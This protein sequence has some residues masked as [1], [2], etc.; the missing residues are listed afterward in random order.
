M[1]F[2]SA[3]ALVSTL[4][5]HFSEG[6]TQPVRL[7]LSEAQLVKELELEDGKLRDFITSI[8]TSVY[9]GNGSPFTQALDHQAI[10]STATS[11][12]APGKKTD[13]VRA[14]FQRGTL[15][16]WESSPLVQDYLGK[17]FKFLRARTIEGH[18]GL[19]FRAADDDGGLNY[20][21]LKIGRYHDDDYRIR[22]IFI[23]GV[24]E[25][26]SDTLNRTFRH[27]ASEFAPRSNVVVENREVSAAFVMSLSRIAEMNRNFQSRNYEKVCQIYDQL[28]EAAK[29]D[30]K[31]MLLR[32]EAAE[33]LETDRYHAA[34]KDWAKVFP[35]EESLPL[36]FIEY[37]YSQGKYDAA[38]EVIRNLNDRIGGDSYLK[39][40]LGEVLFAKEDQL[41]T[42]P[43]TIRNADEPGSASTRRGPQP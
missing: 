8:E 42:T 31:V 17:H 29:L 22:D 35:G 21:L 12:V 3:L 19:L 18:E 11:G 37:Y 2:L 33:H 6:E 10:L 4:I 14:M 38:A 27:L 13:S 7:S 26:V 32:L 28:P 15:S 1:R 34:M 25:A 9:S 43:P 36:K 39:F 24:N 16:A 40:R 30:H 41:Q 23:V 20:Y 5:S